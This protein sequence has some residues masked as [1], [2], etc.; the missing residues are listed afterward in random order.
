MK[1]KVGILVFRDVEV[2]DF[3]GPFEVFSVASQLHNR[4]LFDVCLIAKNKKPICAVN[5]LSVNPHY[6]YDDAPNLDILIVAGGSGTKDLLK[7]QSTLKWV[8]NTIHNTGLSLSICSGSRILGKLGVLDNKSYCTHHEVYNHMSELV[9]SGKPQYGERFV[10]SDTRLYTS[11]GISAGID[12]SFHI[13]EKLHGIKV[14][15]S[16]AIYMEYNGYK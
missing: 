3:A 13:V 8:E 6:A 2:L 15:R 16:T 14:A 10:Q 5:G 4:A 1:R 7:D 11:G 12:L 9:P